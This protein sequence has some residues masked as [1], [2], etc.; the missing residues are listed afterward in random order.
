[1]KGLDGIQGP[2]YVG[3]GCVFNR[4]ALYGYGPPSLPGLP[5]APPPSRSWFGKRSS[6]EPSKDPSEVYRDAKQEELDAGIFNLKEIESKSSC[7]EK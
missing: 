2:F 6:K 5:T 4:Q 7:E 1:M 3:T